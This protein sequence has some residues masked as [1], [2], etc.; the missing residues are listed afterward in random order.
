MGQTIYNG[1]ESEAHHSKA[2]V[3]GTGAVGTNQAYSG[4]LV[5]RREGLLS[6]LEGSGAWGGGRCGSEAT[7]S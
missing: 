4:L 5:M 6:Q 2:S 7:A 3:Q 1:P